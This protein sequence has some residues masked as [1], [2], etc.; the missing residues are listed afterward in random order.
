[1]GKHCHGCNSRNIG[2][3]LA[4]ASLTFPQADGQPRVFVA[5]VRG[6]VCR[7]CKQNVFDAAHL[8]AFEHAVAFELTERGFGTPEEVKFVRKL[9]GIKATELAS[10]FSVTPTTVSNWETGNTEMPLPS[11]YALANIGG[12]ILK[13][14]PKEEV[15]ERF[16]RLTHPPVVHG[17]IAVNV[18]EPVKAA[19]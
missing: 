5:Q 3:G 17:T 2:D 18:P 13:G 19:S 16:R 6:F 11:R 15:L 8:A 9:A 1:M 12:I 10:L 14:A 4:D 7:D